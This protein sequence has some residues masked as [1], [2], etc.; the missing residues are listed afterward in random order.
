ME[1]EPQ[2]PEKIILN[3]LDINSVLNKFDGVKLV[4]DNKID[5]FLISKVKQDDSFYLGQFLNESS[6]TPDR[7]DR[8]YK[9]G[10]LILN[11]Q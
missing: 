1:M 5:I 3:H 7:H 9:I 2:S 8:N 10:K 11:I 4:I 6:D